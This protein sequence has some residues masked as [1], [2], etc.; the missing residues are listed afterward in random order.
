MGKYYVHIKIAI[1]KKHSEQN[2]HQRLYNGRS[3]L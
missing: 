3:Y 2:G 1:P